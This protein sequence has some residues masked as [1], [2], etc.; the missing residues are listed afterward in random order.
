VFGIL[1]VSLALSKADC[2]MVSDDPY[3][4]IRCVPNFDA[5]CTKCDQI[6]RFSN[7]TPEVCDALVDATY[8]RYFEGEVARLRIEEATF[9]S[10]PPH[11]YHPRSRRIAM[12]NSIDD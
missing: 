10:K 9:I 2:E 12:Q 5:V 4:T 11:A 8:Y 3:E 7:V 1:E 6:A